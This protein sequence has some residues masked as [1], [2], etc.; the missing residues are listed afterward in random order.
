MSA[1]VDRSGWV[2]GKFLHLGDAEAMTEDLWSLPDAQLVELWEAVEGELLL[3][4]RADVVRDAA[5]AAGAGEAG[6]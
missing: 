2:R 5:A 4:E 6:R 1:R 3:R